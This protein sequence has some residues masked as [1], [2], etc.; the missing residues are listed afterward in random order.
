MGASLI[1]L[2]PLKNGT[3]IGN[4]FMSD[5]TAS[6]VVNATDLANVLQL[7]EST[8]VRAEPTT[9]L[10]TPGKDFLFVNIFTVRQFWPPRT[11]EQTFVLLSL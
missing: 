4:V 8:R 7:D 10:R 9:Y 6:D 1:T 5:N 3:V 11:N 2:T